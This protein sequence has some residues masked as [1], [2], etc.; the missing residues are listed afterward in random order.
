M[1]GKIYLLPDSLVSRI[2]NVILADLVGRGHGIADDHAWN[3]MAG[4]REQLTVADLVVF[5]EATRVT[6]AE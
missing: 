4:K 6:V 2:R 3:A 1:D 5:V